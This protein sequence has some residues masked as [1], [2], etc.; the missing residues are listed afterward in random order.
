MQGMRT[1]WR[2]Q[3]VIEARFVGLIFWGR[4]EACS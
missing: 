3:L 1:G 2:R 4:G